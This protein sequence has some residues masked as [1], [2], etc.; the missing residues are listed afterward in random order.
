MSAGKGDKPRPVNLEKYESN[1]DRIFRCR[2]TQDRKGQEVSEN[3]A[4]SCETKDLMPAEDN[5]SQADQ[6]HQM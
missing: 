3:G 4:T 1:F 5:S 6:N 2:S